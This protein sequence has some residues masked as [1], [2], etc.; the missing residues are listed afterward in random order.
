M[1]Y[2]LEIRGV[3]LQFAELAGLPGLFRFVVGDVEYEA[4]AG[5]N[6]LRT[7][8]NARISDNLDHL[9]DMASLY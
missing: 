9:L 2:R 5:V 8:P 3:A 4:M 6:Y 1:K 7:D